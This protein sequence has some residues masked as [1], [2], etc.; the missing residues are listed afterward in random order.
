[1]SEASGRRIEYTALPIDAVRQQN[2]DLARMFEWFDRV[3]YDADIVGLRS[4]YPEVDW[5]RFS[6]WAREQD[7]SALA[8][9]R[10]NEPAKPPLARFWRPPPPMPC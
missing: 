9:P 4:L 2:E 6:V 7:W 10:H 3:G 8:V 1:M 5:H